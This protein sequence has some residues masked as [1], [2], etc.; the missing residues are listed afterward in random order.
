MSDTNVTLPCAALLSGSGAFPN[1]SGS[2]PLGS[3]ALPCASGTLSHGSAALPIGSGSLPI[4]SGSL[5]QVGC[6]G[7][8]PIVAIFEHKETLVRLPLL[9][10]L[11]VFMY[12]CVFVC[13]LCI[14]FLHCTDE[15]QKGEMASF[16]LVVCS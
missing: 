7:Y 10:A 9:F 1:G 13:V 12:V 11:E 3:A 6:Y 4:G 14:L 15:T 8:W 5:S 2:L 16:I